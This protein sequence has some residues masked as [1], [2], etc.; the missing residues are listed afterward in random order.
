MYI[1]HIVD[2]K[3]YCDMYQNVKNQKN[4][5]VDILLTGQYIC[6]NKLIFG[7]IGVVYLYNMATV[8]NHTC[9][10]VKLFCNF[11]L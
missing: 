3:K 10:T 1:K 6:D 9:S 11:S 4:L 5:R 7:C 8:K 2:V